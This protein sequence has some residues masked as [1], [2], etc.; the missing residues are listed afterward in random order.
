MS[1]AQKG[2]RSQGKRARRKRSGIPASLDAANS[3]HLHLN[4]PA[5]RRRGPDAGAPVDARLGYMLD[6]RT[7]MTVDIAAP[8]RSAP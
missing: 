2:S 8:I 7:D 4:F 1:M 6:V 3:A 5:P